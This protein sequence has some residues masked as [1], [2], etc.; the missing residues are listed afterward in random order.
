[1]EFR[2]IPE[3]TPAIYQLKITL[4]G[5]EP[6]IWRR[7]QV[8]STILLCSLHDAIQV[9][10]GWANSHLHEFEGNDLDENQFSVSA[11]LRAVGDTMT[12]VY[13]FGDRWQH[14]VRLSKILPMEKTGIGP[15]CLAGERRCP[16]EDIG[17]VNGYDE[18]MEAIFD[19]D[20]GQNYE[21]FSTWLDAGFQPDDFDLN[22]VNAKLAGMR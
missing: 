12:Y 7:I 4:L 3:A 14:Q 8:P 16:P 18:L 9:A 13:D 1:M 6:P 15:I 10:M 2:N 20:P 22:A 5:I 21:H 19:P 17:G 11:V